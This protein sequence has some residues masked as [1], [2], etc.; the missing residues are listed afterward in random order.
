MIAALRIHAFMMVWISAPRV[1]HFALRPLL[2]SNQGHERPLY[3]LG[4]YLT[5]ADPLPT[6]TFTSYRIT[7]FDVQYWTGSA[8]VTVPG[9]SITGNNLLWRKITFPAVTTQKIR[10]VVNA[11]VD[12]VARIVELEAWGIDAPPRSNVASAANGAVVSSQNFTQDSVFPGA[13]FQPAFAID[14]QRYMHL[15]TNDADGFWRDEHGLSSWLQVDFNGPKVINEVDVFTAADYPAYLTQADPS[16]TQ[17]FT[18]FGITAF[19]V[20]YWTGSA[21]ATVSGG[22]ITGNNLLWRKI[23]FP[24]VTTQR[25]RVKVNAA[26]DGVAR[27]VELEAWGTDAPPQTSVNAAS[28]ANGGTATAQ[29]YTADSTFPGYHWQP[30]YAIDG[31]RYCH[32]IQSGNDGNGIWRDEHGLPSWLEV[33]FNSS[34]TIN[35]IDVY[36]IKDYPALLTQADPSATDTFTQF[37]ATAFDVQYWTGS[38]WATVPGGSITGNTLVWRKITFSPVTTQK[39]RVVVN[40]AVD[41]VARIV[42]LEAWGTDAQ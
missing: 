36:T 23:T 3:L 32:L 22:S 38:A 17:T 5:Q 41:G 11:A 14:G 27:I 6:Q 10:V 4:R 12:G 37:G 40:A 28:A 31:T 9:G 16:P 29:N 35:E 18:S 13:H 2:R 24:A 30:S 25:I 26:V 19:D 42:E 34:K 21:W 39:I 1:L 7:A 33:D 8:W 15:T 20:Q